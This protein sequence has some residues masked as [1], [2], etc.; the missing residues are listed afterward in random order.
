MRFLIC[1]D[2][3]DDRRRGRM[4]ALLMD[5]GT[6]IQESVFVATLDEELRDRM[7]ER[8]R[9]V[10][11]ELED[12]VHVFAIC[13]GC[14]NRVLILGKGDLPTDQPFYIL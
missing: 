1:Y 8:T 3:A 2:I 12:S 7:I 4:A 11:D 14:A 13:A 9:R 6:R 5:F 10:M